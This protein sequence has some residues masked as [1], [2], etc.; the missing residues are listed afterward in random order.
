MRALGL[1]LILVVLVVGWRVVQAE[2]QPSVL[3]VTAAPD[4]P[5]RVQMP[6]RPGYPAPEQLDGGSGGTA[7]VSTEEARS[8]C[9]QNCEHHRFVAIQEGSRTAVWMQTGVAATLDV[10][11]GVSVD[12]WDC[13]AAAVAVGPVTWTGC[14][15][16]LR[17][18]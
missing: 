16:T 2:R 3:F 17:R 9:V 5:Q 18:I 11:A 8:W 6:A 12:G 1:V 13:S 7:G 14:E 15:A 4:S 10:P